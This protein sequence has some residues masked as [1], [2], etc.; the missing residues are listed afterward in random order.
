MYNE[1]LIKL[2]NK[3]LIC[4]GFSDF[5]LWKTQISAIIHIIY[6]IEHSDSK[7]FSVIL[8]IEHVN[9]FVDFLHVFSQNP[10]GLKVIWPPFF[11]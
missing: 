6:P 11:Q 3:P 8:T 7:A 4:K 1:C 5:F 2:S 10:W 9:N